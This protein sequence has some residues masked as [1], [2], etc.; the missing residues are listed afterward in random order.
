MGRYPLGSVLTV[1]EGPA[2]SF[3]LCA[4]GCADLVSNSQED[5]MKQYVHSYITFVAF[6]AVT[7]I[8]VAPI[9]QNLNV[10][11]LKDVLA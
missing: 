11:L 9:A 7:K 3:D 5:I 10:P 8:V 6:L 2:V 4:G 1:C